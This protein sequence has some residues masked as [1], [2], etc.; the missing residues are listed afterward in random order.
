MTA[1]AVLERVAVGMREEAD[2]PPPLGRSCEACWMLLDRPRTASGVETTGGS[3][4]R[5]GGGSEEGGEEEGLLYQDITPTHPHLQAWSILTLAALCH[6]VSWVG[7]S[8][9]GKVGGA[10]A[11]SATHTSTFILELVPTDKTEDSPV[12]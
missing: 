7:V 12:W 1:A 5:G 2:W 8:S 6:Q 10:P 9:Q 3:E 4:R 11:P